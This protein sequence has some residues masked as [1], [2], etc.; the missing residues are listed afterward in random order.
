MSEHGRREIVSA[1]EGHWARELAFGMCGAVL[2]GAPAV[3]SASPWVWWTFSDRS[4]PST[5][6]RCG[7]T[8]WPHTGRPAWC[9]RAV[10]RVEAADTWKHDRSAEIAQQYSINPAVDPAD[11]LLRLVPTVER[12]GWDRI[13]SVSQDLTL[14]RIA[15][16]ALAASISSGEAPML[17]VTLSSP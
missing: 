16:E 13:D 5:S 10:A 4:K 3:G 2:S 15:G 9:S 7:P 1:S 14:L 8:R 11:A 17:H 12:L 6:M